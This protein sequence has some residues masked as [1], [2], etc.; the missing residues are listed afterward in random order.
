MT[1]AGN[2]RDGCCPWPGAIM[3]ALRV[4]VVD[5][6]A[7]L[8]TLL[9][10]MLEAMGHRVCAVEAT[11]ADA[12]LAAIRWHPDLMI[13]DVRLGEGSGVVAVDAI[14]LTGTIAHVFVSG[15]LSAVQAQRPRSVSLQ[16]PFRECELARAIRRAQVVAA[17]PFM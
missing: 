10:E 3:K 7:L 16:K 5:D 4:L 6:D 12:V 8:G 1:R 13:V 14:L 15:D 11:E 17:T 9:A 2:G